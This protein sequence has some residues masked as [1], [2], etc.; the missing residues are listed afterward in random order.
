MIRAHLASLL[1]PK[2]LPAD[3]LAG[4][5]GAVLSLPQSIAFAMLAGLPPEY[6]I[7]TAIVPC[8]IAA[9]FG[10]SRHVVSGP[11]N[12]NSLALLAALA[13]LAAPGS[14]EFIALALAV[15]GLV[16][17]MQ[18]TLGAFRLGWV[19]D[20]IAPAVLTGFISGA[21]ILIG[22]YALPDAL[23]L[24]L[25]ERHGVAGTISA[26]AHGIGATNP[27]ALAIAALTLAVTLVGRRISGKLPFMLIGI[28]AGYGASELIVTLPGMPEVARVGAL[29]SVL[30]PLSLP[31]IPID[32]LP[33]LVS[34]AGALSIVALG[35]SV[36]IAKALARRSGDHIDVDRE[37]IGQGLSNVVGCFFSSYVSCG[38][39]NRSLPNYLAGARTPMAAVLSAVFL[40]GLVFATRP[41]LERLPM[42]AIAALLIYIA[43]GL[44]DL[45]RFEHLLRV[46][47]AEFVVA[48]VTLAGILVL[49][50]QDAILIGGGL[51]LA[52]YLRRTAHPAVRTLLPDPRSPAHTFV[53]IEELPGSPA[54]C[55]QLRLVRIEGS[56]YFG[57]AGNVMRRLQALR[58]GSGQRHML[59]MVKS[60]NFIDLAGAEVL[61]HE[62]AM[63]RAAGGDLYFHRPRGS[64]REMWRRTGFD[65]RLGAGHVFESKTTAISV[66]YQHLD[67]DICATCTVRLFRECRRQDGSGGDEA[68]HISSA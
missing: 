17:V 27:S 2:T 10:S 9:L 25:S 29:P 3:A 62:L 33:E 34:I 30:P 58:A 46:S 19:T 31:L 53:P 44:I 26:I 68:A 13:P 45:R 39:L 20:F 60:M 38:S 28:L 32:R 48:L 36:S 42:P 1:S 21:A 37:F 54:E 64:V 49:P 59:A 51:S 41:V 67:R 57:A 11:T 23:G 6:G 12:A 40:V 47:R 35:Q 55:P 18:L 52:V 63:R 50:F 8:I 5:L 65:E 4:L 22:L 56:I 16:G 15:T 43:Y 66:I 61:E 24:A 14:P 7:Y